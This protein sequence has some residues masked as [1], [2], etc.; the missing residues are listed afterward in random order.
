MI[1]F[2]EKQKNDLGIQEMRNGVT[3]FPQINEVLNS[4]NMFFPHIYIY[5]KY[6]Y[7]FESFLTSHRHENY[8]I[9]KHISNVIFIPTPVTIQ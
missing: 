4:E 5:I 9:N 3:Q 8:L 6:I 1:C 7:F 2:V